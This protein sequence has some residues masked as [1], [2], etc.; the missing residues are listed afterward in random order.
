MEMPLFGEDVIWNNSLNVVNE[1]IKPGRDL[2]GD[3]PSHK[4]IRWKSCDLENNK[5]K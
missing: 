5:T 1:I 2:K 4:N 3:Q